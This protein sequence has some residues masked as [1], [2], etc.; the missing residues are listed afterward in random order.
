MIISLLFVASTNA[1]VLNQLAGMNKL[2]LTMLDLSAL[3]FPDQAKNLV[4][5]RAKGKSGKKKNI[6]KESNLLKPLNKTTKTNKKKLVYPENC[7][8]WSARQINRKAYEHRESITKYS[9]QYRVDSNLIKSVI[10]AES[11]FKT[12]ALSNKG[13]R[14]LMQLIPDTAKR[15]GVKNIYN[16]EQNI[17]GGTKYLK[18]L[19]ERY[20]GELNKVI[21]AYN[22]GEG[23]VDKYKGIPPFRETKQYV[24]N[25]LKIYKA[26]TPKKII[27]KKKAIVKKSKPKPKKRIHAVYKPP[28]LGGKPGRHGWQYNRRLAPQLYK[29]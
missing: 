3:Q 11:C 21:A 29:H 26:L 24:E 7:L 18:F 6:K 13:A 2:Q 9:R 14:G 4:K 17:H 20:K 22:A 19:I 5:D 10:T 12:S 27:K 16:P 1:D 25:V 8:K 28:K 23:N 15:F